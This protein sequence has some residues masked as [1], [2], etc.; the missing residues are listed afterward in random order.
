MI[1]E[2]IVLGIFMV[3][4]LFDT[5]G[6]EKS[7]K[8][9]TPFTTILFLLGTIA[10]WIVPASGETIFGGMYINNTATNA[11]KAILNVG[12]FIVFLQSAKW[13]QS[14]EVA[15]R[16]GEFYELLLVT[17]FGMYLM[18]SAR[19]FL[20]FI[21][22]LESASLPLA[23]LVAFNKRHYESHEAA[24]K[25]IMTA[26]FSSAILLTGLS[27]VYAFSG[28]SLY[29]SDIAMNIGKGEMSGLL[30]VALAFVIAGIG[31]KLSLVP[32]HLWTA[33]V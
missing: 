26:V 12:V 2:L 13:A 32:L 7:K 16:K 30:L 24:I 29:F 6:G 23:A 17:L 18:V 15:I 19:H 33:D 25:Y 3:V 21:I 1:P 10:I 9:L 31:F 11:I 4:F 20:L 22:G 5:F 14:D 28:G 27:F 8:I